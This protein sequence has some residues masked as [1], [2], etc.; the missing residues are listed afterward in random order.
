MPVLPA[1]LPHRPQP[2]DAHLPAHPAIGPTGQI[3][4]RHD[5][6]AVELAGILP[7]D[8]PHVADL[9]RRQRL[10]APG[11][12]GEIKDAV[13]FHRGLGDPV[14]DLRQR[15]GLGDADTDRQSG[16]LPHRP[17]HRSA[18]RRE[19]FRYPGEIE[20]TFVDRVLLHR[21]SK[22]GQ[23]LHHPVAHVRIELEVA[24]D[25]RDVMPLNESFAWN[26]GCAILIPSALASSLRATMQPSF[27]DSTT[28]GR[29]SSAGTEHALAGDEEVIAIDQPVDRHG[30]LRTTPET[31]PHTWA[32]PPSRSAKG[33]TVSSPS[34]AATTIESRPGVR[35]RSTISVSPARIPQADG[36][37]VDTGRS[38]S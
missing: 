22:L 31:T 20:E 6:V 4:R 21:W 2:A 9:R 15:L 17:S 35:E 30:K 1:Q 33:R 5:V 3:E 32:S 27:D 14:G 26:A 37:R 34:M 13:G 23:G 7:A 38:H 12:V 18:E 10:V 29:P 36:S 28:V 19:I 24:A 11:R 25:N 8:P 16:P